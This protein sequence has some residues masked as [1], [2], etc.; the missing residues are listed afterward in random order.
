M[1]AYR[2]QGI[3]KFDLGGWYNGTT[4]QA[5]LGINKFKEGFGGKVVCEYEGEQIL[6]LKAWAAVN[7][8]RFLEKLKQS[9]PPG[10]LQPEPSPERPAVTTSKSSETCGSL[11]HA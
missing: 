4:D 8:A 10:P 1:L 2:N 6:S 9:R 3:E 5:R 11:G 7:M